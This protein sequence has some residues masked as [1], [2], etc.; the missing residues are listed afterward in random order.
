MLAGCAVGESPE[1]PAGAPSRP[2]SVVLYRD[3]VTVRFGDG[4]LCVMP[5]E[6]S[7]G[8]WSGRLAG[9]PYL[10]PA[11]VLRSTLQPRLPLRVD[12][13]DPWVRLHGPGGPLSYGV[14][15]EGV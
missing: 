3:T 5:R 13:A 2:V 1:T 6:A 8:A 9:C 10:W 4:A 15:A 14:G 11:E 12:A 7:S